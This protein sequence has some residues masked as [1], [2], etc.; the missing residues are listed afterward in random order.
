MQRT[1]VALDVEL[2]GLDR[3]RDEIVEIAMVRFRGDEVLDT[4]SSLVYTRRPISTRVAQ[5]TGL[6]SEDLIN[7]PRLEQ[8]RGQILR[9]VSNYPVVGHSIETDLYFM[10]KQGLSLQN[11]AI[12]TFELAS[13]LVP[14]ANTY[15]LAALSE[16]LGQPIDEAHRALPDAMAT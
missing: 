15:S 11:V 9:F 8:L 13:I 1:Y 4:F 12:D 16:L 10:E 3:Q 5:L 7:A 6:S 2:T 14:E